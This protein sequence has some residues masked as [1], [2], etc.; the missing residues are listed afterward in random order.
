[1]FTSILPWGTQF[2]PFGTMDLNGAKAPGAVLIAGNTRLDLSHLNDSKGHRPD[3]D[4]ADDFVI[5]QLAGNSTVTLPQD[6]STKVNVRVLA[7][8][9]TEQQGDTKLNAAGPFLGKTI[10]ANFSSNEGSSASVFQVTVYLLA[11]N[12]KVIDPQ[13]TTVSEIN[14]TSPSST[15]QPSQRSSEKMEQLEDKLATVEWQLDE[16][17]LSRSDRNKLESE[18]AQLKQDIK[19]LELEAAR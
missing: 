14:P 1:M 2:Q 5:W 10:T 16:P 6:R 8:N 11:G 12:V 3:A 17:G 19:D 9:I 13:G 15:E 7:G 4:T 18:R